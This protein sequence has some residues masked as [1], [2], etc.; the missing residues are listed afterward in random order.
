MLY[1]WNPLCEAP[2]YCFEGS[3]VTAG[4]HRPSA[5][6]R[7]FDE[8]CRLVLH[9]LGGAQLLMFARVNIQRV[10]VR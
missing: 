2:L 8:Q 9:R 4:S 7:T 10:Q 3:D 5:H 6:Y 1:F